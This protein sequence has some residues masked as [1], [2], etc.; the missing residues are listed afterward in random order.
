MP[1]KLKGN[2]MSRQQRY[3]VRPHGGQHQRVNLD[4][5]HRL[6]ASARGTAPDS[7]LIVHDIRIISRIVSYENPCVRLSNFCPYL[8]KRVYSCLDYGFA[9]RVRPSLSQSST[10]KLNCDYVSILQSCQPF[11]SYRCH[12]IDR[13]SNKNKL[14]WSTSKLTSNIPIY[15]S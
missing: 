2:R 7:K 13:L 5:A 10:H 3:Q 8:V 9:E 11:Q 1:G 12:Y 14:N 15:R 6:N 4:D